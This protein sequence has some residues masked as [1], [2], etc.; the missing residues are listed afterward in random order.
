M[1][2]GKGIFI[3]IVNYISLIVSDL[4][5]VSILSI[6]VLLW[7][8]SVNGN[9]V[10]IASSIVLHI[11]WGLDFIFLWLW[12]GEGFFHWFWNRFLWLFL[13][14]HNIDLLGWLLIHFLFWFLLLWLWLLWSVLVVLH[15]VSSLVLR[16]L[17]LFS[18]LMAG[19]H[20]LLL[21]FLLLFLFPSLILKSVNFLLDFNCELG[22]ERGWGLLRLEAV[23]H[24][25]A[26][27]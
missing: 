20:L 11:I 9:L 16:I 21:P 23:V 26:L 14:L 6:I 24:Q 15:I 5:I 27:Y 7:W 18:V 12:W 2:G 3:L 13:S 17:L 10:F 22:R 25:K 1:K 19:V 4:D 8:S